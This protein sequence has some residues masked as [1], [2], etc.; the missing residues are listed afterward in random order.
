MGNSSLAM[1]SS[2]AIVTSLWSGQNYQII[3]ENIAQTN[4][5]RM[6]KL[7]GAMELI[8]LEYLIFADSVS[9]SRNFLT[10]SWYWVGCWEPKMEKCRLGEVL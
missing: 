7:E 10:L 4:N 1:T 2:L 9:L 8:Y 5:Q 3:F 6:L